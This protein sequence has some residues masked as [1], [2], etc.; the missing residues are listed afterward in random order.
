MRYR[1][2]ETL[3]CPCEDCC[4]EYCADP[5]IQE[6]LSL[7]DALKEFCDLYPDAHE[8][9]ECSSSTY[10]RGSWVSKTG[11]TYGDS[12][13]DGEQ[14]HWGASFHFVD[15]WGKGPTPASQKRVMRLVAKAVGADW[16]E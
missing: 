14:E 2:I 8:H 11:V 5:C 13:C 15:T 16:R 10:H 12:A 3:S 6:F 9:A 1:V 7:R 4:G